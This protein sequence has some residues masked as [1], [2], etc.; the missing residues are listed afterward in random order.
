MGNLSTNHPL[1]VLFV[2]DT[3]GKEGGVVSGGVTYYFET[4]KLIDRTKIEPILCILR[5]RDSIA[6]RFKEIGISPIFLSRKKWDPRAFFDLVHLLREYQVDILHLEGKK[7][8]ILGPLAARLTGCPAIIHL[9]DMVPV[10]PW[11]SFFIRRLT[12]WT[13]QAI[14]NSE[15]V[16]E[17]GIQEFGVPKDKTEVLYYGHNLDLFSILPPDSSVEARMKL[18]LDETTPTIGVIG[19]IVNWV[20]GQDLMIRAMPKLLKQNPQTT[21]VI[22][23]DGPDLLFCQSLAKQL[24]VQES[25]LFTGQRDDIP[26]MFAA[27][28]VLAIPSLNDAF[29]FV[30]MEGAA[31]GKP[32]VA[33]KTGGIPEIVL[34]RKT[35]LIVEKGDIEGLAEA[36]NQVLMDKALAKTLGE[37]GRR[38]AQ[39]FTLDRHL[40]RLEEIYA[41][42][43]AQHRS[44]P[45]IPTD[46][47]SRPK[48]NKG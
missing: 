24:G 9:H 27:I 32:I 36:L 28:D 48:V 35:G 38:H 21:L 8:L 42:V 17:R 12:P 37:E 44:S 40:K 14:A 6:N 4:L 30:A 45:Q 10:S 26:D 33:F 31:S 39:N 18:G 23:G 1:R 3:L 22:V 20:K 41:N 43:V 29:A 47:V 19:R 15:A 34:H 16:R 2:K 7:S 11:V 25:V 13:A 5:P 46:K